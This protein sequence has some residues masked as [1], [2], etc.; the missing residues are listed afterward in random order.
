[1]ISAF[2]ANAFQVNPLAFQ[3]SQIGGRSG[4]VREW[5]YK[6]QEESLAADAAKKE[7]A[8]EPMQVSLEVAAKA[9]PAPKKVR[10]Q[11]ERSQPIQWPKLLITPAPETKTAYDLLRDVAPLPE[12]LTGIGGSVA[13]KLIDFTAVR[14]AAKQ[15][16]KALKKKRKIALFMLL[17]A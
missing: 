3:I 16:K 6:L 8:A 2:Q 14:E 9:Q 4:V 5:V 10:L 15:R 13:S 12:A 11:R 17:A 1:V 7:K